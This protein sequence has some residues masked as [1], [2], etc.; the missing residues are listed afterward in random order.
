MW[1]GMVCG[2]SGWCLDGRSATMYGQLGAPVVA[3]VQHHEAGLAVLGPHGLDT[4]ADRLGVGHHV[5]A[6]A[7]ARRARSVLVT[8]N[9]VK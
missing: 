5:D 6:E 7:A 3:V 8:W 1:P 9:D 4:V 2:T